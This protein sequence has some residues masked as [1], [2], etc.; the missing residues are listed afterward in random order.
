[1]RVLMLEFVGKREVRVRKRPPSDKLWQ[2][3]KE[4]PTPS[5]LFFVPT[6]KS[7]SSF[8]ILRGHQ[9]HIT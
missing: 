7:Q 1:L 9:H 8:V 2:S 6:E 4:L 3:R 5:P